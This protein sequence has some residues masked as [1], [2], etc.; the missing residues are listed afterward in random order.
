MSSADS[1][2]NSWATLFTYDFYHR[3]VNKDASHRQLLLVGRLATIFLLTVGV[4]RAPTLRGNESILQFFLN[5]LA[6]ISA[7]VFVIFLVGIFW[8]RAT[9]AGAIAALLSA[10][11]LCYGAQHMRG[12]VGWGPHQ[13]SIVNWLPIAVATLALVMITV[14]L[15]TRPKEPALLEG[16]IWTP[17]DT[18][19]FGAHLLE[20]LDVETG[21]GTLLWGG[22]L[23]IWRDYRL[24]GIVV[25]V[26]LGAII[27]FLR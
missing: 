23:P 1:T 16:L 17:R 15:L 24:V 7:P 21:K 2:T 27:W 5:G 13:T 20:R 6:Y 25:L 11:A 12:L 22:H 19:T 14:S 26:L 4:L 8:R 3:V 18:L 9:S 10:P